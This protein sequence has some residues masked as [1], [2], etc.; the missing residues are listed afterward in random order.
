LQKAKGIFRDSFGVTA[1]IAILN[2]SAVAL[3]AD[4]AVTIGTDR[5]PK[6]FNTVNKLFTLSKCHPV[7]AMVYG[8]AHLMNVPWETIVKIYRAKLRD[9]RFAH[10]EDYASDLLRYLAGNRAL[11]PVAAQ[12][13]YFQ[14]LVSAFYQC[15]NSEIQTEVRKHIEKTGSI[16]GSSVRRIV[17]SCIAKHFHQLK[18]CKT[19][20][21]FTRQF[22]KRLLRKYSSVLSKLRAQC[23]QKLPLASGDLARI[24]TMSA[25]LFTKDNFRLQGISGLVIAGFGEKDIYPRF[26]EFGIEGVIQDKLR[27][28]PRR[29]TQVGVDCVS[30]VV[31]FAQIEVVRGFV[32]GVDPG[33]QRLLDKFLDEIFANYP[34]VLLNHVKGLTPA[35]KTAAV[36]KT[37]A[38]GEKILKQFRQEFEEFRRKTLVNPIVS[39]VAVL[40]KDELAAMAEALVNLTSFK[41]RF[42]PNA[43]TVGG[44]IDVAVISKG[45]GFIWVKHKHYFKP[46]LNPHF[47][48]NYFREV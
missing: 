1:E 43:E 14:R 26:T 16:S 44:P 31:P 6:I 46:E 22:E 20:R 10:L 3:A 24:R 9:R 25:W 12:T 48:T 47:S 34:S 4:S 42:S 37:K 23:F 40:P 5:G 35:A 41:R 38:A 29:H 30:T 21:G 15:I 13:E 17:Q 28:S 45:D 33:M 2:K 11:F 18:A 36:K 19:L 8:N 39:T 7:G 27:F 32:E